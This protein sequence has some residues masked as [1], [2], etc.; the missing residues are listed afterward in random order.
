MES[1]RIVI[2]RRL[3]RKCQSISENI[4]PLKSSFKSGNSI[5]ELKLKI[6]D[7]TNTFEDISNI[8]KVTEN[9]MI[10][11]LRDIREIISNQ[12][13]DKKNLKMIVENLFEMGISEDLQKLELII[14][15][16]LQRGVL[17]TM[18]IL[19]APV[20]EESP[21]SKD[22]KI[23]NTECIPIKNPKQRI[24]NPLTKDIQ[25]NL[26]P[27]KSSKDIK[28]YNEPNELFRQ[29]KKPKRR[30]NRTTRTLTTGQ[31]VK[32]VIERKS[33]DTPN[34]MALKRSPTNLDN[35][36]EFKQSIRTNDKNHTRSSKINSNQENKIKNLNSN[37]ILKSSMK[38]RDSKLSL[39]NIDH[40]NLSQ[41][42]FKKSECVPKSFKQENKNK[43]DPIERELTPKTIVKNN[44][45]SKLL[46][47][48][49]Q[50]KQNKSRGTLEQL[51]DQ[52]DIKVKGL[53]EILKKSKKGFKD[54][55]RSFGWSEHE[56][57][58]AVKT[59]DVKEICKENK[60]YNKELIKKITADREPNQNE[61]ID[62]I[63]RDERV[64]SDFT[65]KFKVTE[66]KNVVIKEYSPYGYVLKDVEK[67]GDKGKEISKNVVD[68]HSKQTNY[69]KFNL[70]GV[71]AREA[72]KS[73]EAKYFEIFIFV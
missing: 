37:N 30:K 35:D 27:R 38:N 8:L 66:V 46:Q 50:T 32:K 33:A 4:D 54:F 55:L 3:L 24:I 52:R 18:V 67:E 11:M 49:Q 69:I 43:N 42:E 44:P 57:E 72:R 25:I 68:F 13:I 40:Q 41:F 47:I 26:T 14:R 7:L 60:D 59:A 71:T 1:K 48:N 45:K 62:V 16:T 19:E 10:V 20:F 63:N 65:E 58:D 64:D 29:T 12:S 73:L 28:K 36:I 22:N 9:K 23:R 53:K 51:M 2:N 39:K 61:Q 17:K 6:H 5:S 70:N 15:E 56:I 34:Q 21:Y 31:S